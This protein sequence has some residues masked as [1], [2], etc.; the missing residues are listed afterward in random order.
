MKDYFVEL[1]G[2][3]KKH[4]FRVE[5]NFTPGRAF[6]TSP[7][8]EEQFLSPGEPDEVDILKVYLEND[9]GKERLIDPVPD[10]LLE[11]L[12]EK[13]IEQENRGDC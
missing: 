5:A 3:T 12:E 8:N 6:V 13:I 11:S 9:N 1:W 10:L 2:E 7:T 4:S